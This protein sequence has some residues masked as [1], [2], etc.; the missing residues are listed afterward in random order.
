[1]NERILE[2][3]GVYHAEGTWLGELRY[4]F[5]K[6]RGTAHCELC[7]ITHDLVREKTAFQRLRLALPI[8][9]RTL[10]LDERDDTL[11]RFTEGLTPCV[12]GRTTSGWTLLLDS[13]TLASCSKD[14]AKFERLL[15]TQLEG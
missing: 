12:V 14:V 11:T 10:H 5:G 4:L 8:P 15:R 1:M 6:W 3:V 13:Q 2:V 7:D 9:L